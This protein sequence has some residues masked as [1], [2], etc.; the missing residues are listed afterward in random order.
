MKRKISVVITVCLLSLTTATVLAQS[1]GN[2]DL[3]WS[4]LNGGGGEVSGGRFALIS[5]IGQ[6]EAGTLNGGSYTL[7]GGFLAGMSSP[8]PANGRVYLPL[9]LR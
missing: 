2:Y 6:A 1:G 5:A 4:S 3:T 7:S 9:V 8:P